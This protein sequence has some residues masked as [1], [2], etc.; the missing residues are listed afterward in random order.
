M[1]TATQTQQLRLGDV[2]KEAGYVTEEQIEYVINQQKASGVKKRLGEALI[3]NNVITED[4]LNTALSKRLNIPYVSMSD[5]PVDLEAVKMIPKA[6]AS[7]H[8]LIAIGLDH[9]VL[10]INI[11]DPLDYYALEDV[12]LITHMQL[13]TQICNRADIMQA[14]NE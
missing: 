5:A 11:N 12:K 7:K 1:P 9:T 10:R 8:C 4:R 2:L 14:I 6:V 13:E 3:E